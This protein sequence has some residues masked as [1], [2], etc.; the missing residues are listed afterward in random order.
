M[1]DLEV[2]NMENRELHLTTC[3]MYQCYT[4]DKRFKANQ[5]RDLKKHIVK[6]HNR[7]NGKYRFNK[8]YLTLTYYL[9]LTLWGIS[10]PDVETGSRFVPSEKN[11]DLHL[12][13]L[14]NLVPFQGFSG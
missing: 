8:L 4:C 5:I 7:K 11:L 10:E 12:T 9:L 6:E 3:E 14:R 1:C 2:T 13:R